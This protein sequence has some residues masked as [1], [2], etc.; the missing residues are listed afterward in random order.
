MRSFMIILLICVA[1][2]NVNAG[3]STKIFP[4]L[5]HGKVVRTGGQ[6]NITFIQFSNSINGPFTNPATIGTDDSLFIKMDVS[7][8]GTI[9]AAYYLDVNENDTIDGIDPALGSDTYID[10]NTSPPGMIDLDPTPGL[11]IAYRG[12]ECAPSMKV[13]VRA[14]EDLSIVEGVI[15]FQNYATLYTLS[16]VVHNTVGGVVPG[17]MVWVADSSGE[18]GDVSDANGNYS[19]P[20]NL[21]TSYVHVSDFVGVYS[22]FDT[23]MTFTGN[24][25]QD[26]YLSMLTSYLR[27]Y[28]KDETSV[29]IPNVEVW[30][31][32]GGYAITDENGMY[33]AMVPSGTSYFGLSESDLLPTYMVPTTHQFTIGE[34]DSIVNNSITN[35]TCYRTNSSITGTVYE[36]SG[37]PTRFYKI[38]AWENTLQ[39]NSM[40]VTNSS[41]AYTLPVYNSASMPMYSVSI[42]DWDDDYP[43]PPGMYPDTNYWGLSPGS[44]ANFNLISAETSYVDHFYGNQVPPSSTMWDQYGFGNPWGP[45]ATVMCVNDRLKVMCNSNDVLSGLG[46]MSRKPFSLSNREF[47][48]FVDATEMG[49]TNNTIKIVLTDQWWNWTHPQSFENSLQLIWE[50]NGLGYRQW[51]LVKSENGFFSDLCTSSDSSGQHILLQFIDPNVLPRHPSV[52]KYRSTIS[53]R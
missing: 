16:G 30:I 53:F 42:A 10:N 23:M 22:S 29:P 51:R 12:P 31:E 27:G 17:A 4:N 40:A 5:K 50:K 35:F 41:G 19:V 32:N 36:N 11:I 33:V 52:I 1:F 9:M 44:V 25:V 21:G 28:V 47:R 49:V 48:V 3:V 38:F 45:N 39:S 6:G 46:V 8:F 14:S 2:S 13:I 43:F 20:I 18:V 15:N 7:P 37:L 34:N 26:F 24:T